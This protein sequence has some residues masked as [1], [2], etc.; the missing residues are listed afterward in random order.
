MAGRRG[1]VVHLVDQLRMPAQGMDSIGHIDVLAFADRL[2]TVQAFQHGELVGVVFQQLG[3]TQEHLL[4]CAGRQLMPATILERLLGGTHG[5]VDVTGIARRYLCKLF[6]RGRV[7]RD[8]GFSR[9]CITELA[10]DECLGR[11]F[12]LGG[13]G[14]VLFF[15]Q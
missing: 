2:A 11:K 6:T 12:Q 13:D 10:V 7:R 8:E 9:E 14:R 1:A 4:T 3:E 15:A 5:N